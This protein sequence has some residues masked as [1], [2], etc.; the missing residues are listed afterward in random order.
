MIQFI[1]ATVWNQIPLN[2]INSK[3]KYTFKSSFKMFFQIIPLSLRGDALNCIYHTVCCVLIVLFTHC[4]CI[5]YDKLLAFIVSFLCIQQNTTNMQTPPHIHHTIVVLLYAI[6]YT[7][8]LNCVCY[9]PYLK[10]VCNDII[11]YFKQ[12]KNIIIKLP[13]L[14]ALTAIFEKTVPVVL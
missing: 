5:H 4:F 14:R 2:V 1:T 7:C 3:S 8:L 9:R 11:C 10:Y 13:E 6:C 12:I